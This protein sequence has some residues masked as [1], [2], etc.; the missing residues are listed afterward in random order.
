MIILYK[1]VIL[2]CFGR[3]FTVI[4]LG[5]ISWPLYLVLYHT[6][7]FITDWHIPTGCAS[8]CDEEAILCGR[9]EFQVCEG[10]PT[11]SR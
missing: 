2:V 3:V 7:L 8:Q 5:S 9:R 4:L 6:S 10:V 1:N 11:E